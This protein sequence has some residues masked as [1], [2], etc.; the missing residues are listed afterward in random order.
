[1][2]YRFRIENKIY[3]CS[4]SQNLGI[5]VFSCCDSSGLLVWFMA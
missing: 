5:M 1:M 4:K 2:Q 3:K